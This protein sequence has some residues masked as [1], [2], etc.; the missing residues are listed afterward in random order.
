MC[1]LVRLDLNL[2]LKKKNKKTN[3]FIPLQFPSVEDKHSRARVNMRIA[4]NMH[5]KQNH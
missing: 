1:V 3:C 5:C 2:W 4:H